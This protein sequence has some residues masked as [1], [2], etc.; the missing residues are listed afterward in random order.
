MVDGVRVLFPMYFSRLDAMHNG[1]AAAPIQLKVTVTATAA[2][3]IFNC[4][5]PKADATAGAVAREGSAE[6]VVVL[7]PEMPALE[8]QRRA[9]QHALL[10]GWG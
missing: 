4:T 9:M 10:Q 2:P 8:E 7:S 1:S 6:R 3:C 5:M